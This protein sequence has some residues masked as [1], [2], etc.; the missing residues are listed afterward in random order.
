MEDAAPP[1]EPMPEVLP[2]SGPAG[3]RI[4]LAWRAMRDTVL[5]LNDARGVGQP[6]LEEAY[7]KQNDALALL[8]K[9]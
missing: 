5:A 6:G 3:H 4:R 8:I 7:A 1:A 9:V 2:H